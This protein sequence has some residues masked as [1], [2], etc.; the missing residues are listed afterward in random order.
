MTVSRDELGQRV[1]ALMA[2]VRAGDADA[3]GPALG[4][5]LTTIFHNV[6]A[7]MGAVVKPLGRRLDAIDQ[8]LQH[9]TTLLHELHTR[10]DAYV[11]RTEQLE[12][13]ERERG[14]GDGQR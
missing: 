10:L 8:T 5:L 12:D 9:Y 14:A 2:A 1:D 3:I 4:E 6:T 7:T 11:Q 13:R